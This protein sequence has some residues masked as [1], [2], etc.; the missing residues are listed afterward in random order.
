MPVTLARRLWLLASLFL[1]E[2]QEVSQLPLFDC[3]RAMPR[4]SDWMRR[5]SQGKRGTIF[6][7]R[8]QQG[9]SSTQG[10]GSPLTGGACAA[11][12]AMLALLIG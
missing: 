10:I 12:A 1:S 9:L 3:L 8:K 6:A 11:A 4:L 5:P 2:M 7:T